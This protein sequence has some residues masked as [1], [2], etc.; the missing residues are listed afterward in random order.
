MS[1]RKYVD[2]SLKTSSYILVATTKDC[3]RLKPSVSFYSYRNPLDFHL[4][5]FSSINFRFLVNPNGDDDDTNSQSLKGEI[6][7]INSFVPNQI[8]IQSITFVIQKSD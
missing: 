6:I 5:H 7:A 1:R 4:S 8:F 3:P 2:A